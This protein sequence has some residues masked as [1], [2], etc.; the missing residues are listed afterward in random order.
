MC[1][2]GSSVSHFKL[3]EMVL[4]TDREGNATLGNL[5]DRLQGIDEKVCHNMLESY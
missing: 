4:G 2:K 5:F 1:L 3:D